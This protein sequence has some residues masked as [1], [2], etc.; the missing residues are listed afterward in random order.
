VDICVFG[1][2]LSHNF[3]HLGDFPMFNLPIL[4]IAAIISI[5]TFGA[6]ASSENYDVYIN[7]D[8]AQ[9]ILLIDTA[10][11]KVNPKELQQQIV[12]KKIREYLVAALKTIDQ[13]KC[14]ASSTWEAT[15]I[16]VGKRDS[17]GQPDWS[18]VVTLQS[19]NV[20]LEKLQAIRN[21]DL[22]QSNINQVIES[23]IKH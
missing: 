16:T 1:E 18:E 2:A 6:Q 10:S 9:C 11:L 14:S 17:Y 3:F 20:N 8:G 23:K 7:D 22:T 19:F 13:E 4:L 15:A 5:C 21:K 12:Q